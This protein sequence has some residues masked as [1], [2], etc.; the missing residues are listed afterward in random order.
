M[1]S[2][3][4]LDRC[5]GQCELCQAKTE[6]LET[7]IV[8]P[9]TGENVD[10]QVGLCPDCLTYINE[11]ASLHAEHWRCLT[12]AI[13][14]P[15]PAVQVVSYRILK[16]LENQAWAQ[17]SL[18]MIYFDEATQEWA[19][20]LEDAV[21][22]VDSNG[23]LLTQGDNVILI[24]DL[25]VKG[26]NFT[27]KQGTLVKKINLDMSNPQYIEGKINDQYIVILTQYVKKA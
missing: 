23:N 2:T 5:Q 26:A 7:Y 12:E 4:L 15:H 18:S 25:D 24:K 19:E 9:K 11:E 16:T 14:S 6:T 22:H 3:E 21:R 27:A 8:P 13:W 17:D 10:E 1:I 20:N